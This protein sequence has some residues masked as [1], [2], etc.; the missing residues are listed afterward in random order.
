MTRR[1]KWFALMSVVVASVVGC[2]ASDTGVPTALTVYEVKGKVLLADG[3][4]LSG[5]HVYFVSKDGA[6]SPE[7]KIGSDG[8]FAL[9][10][11]PSGEGAPSGEYKVRI[12]PEDAS[13]IGGKRSKKGGKKLSFPTK[14]L[15]EDS[16]GLMVTVK[17]EPNQLEPFR[18]K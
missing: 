5:G 13:L 6:M 2:G 3:S 10:T 17:S 15:D 8:S 11:G 1:S 16:S 14:Y 7:G 4:P 9:V 12:E 18:L